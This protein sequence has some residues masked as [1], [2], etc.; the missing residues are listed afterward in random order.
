MITIK[1]RQEKEY[2]QE[3]T[4]VNLFSCPNEQE[5]I[6]GYFFSR[7]VLNP[8]QRLSDLFWILT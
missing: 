8:Q 3:I 6:Q 5:C 7:H 2:E 4:A 1:V